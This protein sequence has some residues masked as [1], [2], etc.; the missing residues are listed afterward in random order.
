MFFEVILKVLFKELSLL[1]LLRRQFSSNFNWQFPEDFHS[2][3]DIRNVYVV[4]EGI[5]L[6]SVSLRIAVGRDAVGFVSKLDDFRHAL[7]LCESSL[8][9]AQA[10]TVHIEAI[11]PPT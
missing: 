7:V 8:E 11:A 5:D 2:L 3:F 1:K 4:I 6:R 9:F 10:F